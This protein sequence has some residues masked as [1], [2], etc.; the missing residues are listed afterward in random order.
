MNVSEKAKAIF[1]IFV[2]VAG[3]IFVVQ[4]FRGAGLTDSITLA[5][6]CGCGAALGGA[7]GSPLWK[8]S[9]LRRRK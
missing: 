1:L 5:V 3:G 6:F 7:I 2:F 4:A 8:R 9:R